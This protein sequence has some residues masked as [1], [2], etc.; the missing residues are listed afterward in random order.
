MTVALGTLRTNILG[1][2]TGEVRIGA[3]SSAGKLTQANSVGAVQS[4]SFEE[5][6]TNIEAKAGSPAQLVA[7]AVGEKSYSFKAETL[8][9]SSANINA[10]VG[11]G[12]IAGI[13]G[14]ATT[15]TSDELAGATVITLADAA[16]VTPGSM[17]TIYPEGKPEQV[18]T[19][20]VLSKATNEV[21]L[22]PS[23]PLLYDAPAATDTATVYNV[24]V[25]STISGGSVTGKVSTFSL[26]WIKQSVSGKPIVYHFW[27]V[28]AK[29]NFSDSGSSSEF[30][31]VPLEFQ[32]LTPS[33]ADI[34]V[35]G[36][37]YHARNMI[38][39]HPVYVIVQETD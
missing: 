12:F 6:T 8:E 39:K 26:S 23:T 25:S 4:V 28:A 21:T 22:D 32:V 16:S 31:K 19:C 29:G 30:T 24:F 5:S 9:R 7:I 13:V 35:G 36:S 38:A 2:G 37:L 33:A 15:L 1:T 11:N 18:S 20:L 10:A 27:K 14:G 17:L 3:L 34:A